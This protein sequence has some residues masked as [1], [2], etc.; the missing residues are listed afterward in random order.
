MNRGQENNEIRRARNE[1]ARASQLADDV[2]TR[3]HSLTDTFKCLTEIETVTQSVLENLATIKR[4]IEGRC[5]A[6]WEDEA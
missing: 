1:L 5:K 2:V 3:D 4:S 6:F